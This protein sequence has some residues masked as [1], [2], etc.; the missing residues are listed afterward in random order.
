MA[1]IVLQGKIR[2]LNHA[3]GLGYTGQ[4]AERK[5]HIASEGHGGGQA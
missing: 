5:K 3:V 1:H 2:L 4:A